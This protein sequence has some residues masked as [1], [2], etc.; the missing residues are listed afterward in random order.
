MPADRLPPPSQQPWEGRTGAPSSR[1]P[2][3]VALP[4]NRHPCWHGPQG[5]TELLPLPGP[6][7]GPYPLGET[8]AAGLACL[9]T[10]GRGRRAAAVISAEVAPAS[11]PDTGALFPPAGTL[12]ASCSPRECAQTQRAEG[13]GRQ[14]GPRQGPDA[15]APGSCGSTGS[16]SG[17]GRWA[18]PGPLLCPPGCSG[19]GP[20]TREEGWSLS[21]A[22]HVRSHGA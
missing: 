9:H 2:G 1:A 21:P 20:S 13:R 12:G 3:Q 7:Q 14:V 17:W 15:A 6:F 8:K 11:S 5:G 19:R 10:C 16:G 22:Q 4:A 18:G